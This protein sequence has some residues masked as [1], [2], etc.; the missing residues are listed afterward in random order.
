MVKID[1]HLTTLTVLIAGL[2]CMYSGTNSMAVPESVYYEIAEKLE[3]YLN[4][5]DYERISFED[6]IRDCLLILPRVML[7]DDTVNEMIT[8]GLYWERENGNIILSI[9]MSG[10]DEK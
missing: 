1:L 10:L 3:P 9:S 2:Y 4:D 5:W 6:W 7:D 8:D